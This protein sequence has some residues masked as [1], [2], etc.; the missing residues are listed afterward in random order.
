VH[1]QPY[2]LKVLL[3]GFLQ[4]KHVVKGFRE[5]AISSFLDAAYI[6][7]ERFEL[8]PSFNRY[9]SSHSLTMLICCRPAKEIQNYTGNFISIQQQFPCI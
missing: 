9:C 6:L 3:L 1:P 2:R 8:V 4:I 7:R 5:L